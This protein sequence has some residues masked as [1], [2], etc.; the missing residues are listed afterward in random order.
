MCGRV[1]MT[2]HEQG[3]RRGTGTFTG[4]VAA[5]TDWRALVWLLRPCLLAS[6]YRYTQAV[7]EG[8]ASEKD[9]GEESTSIALW[10]LQQGQRMWVRESV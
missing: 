5:A 7:C 10:V 8:E 1:R 4:A 3:H 2:D 9:H 6:L